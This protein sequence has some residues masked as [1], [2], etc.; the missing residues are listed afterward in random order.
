MRTFTLIALL[1][2]AA[3]LTY[4]QNP[5]FVKFKPLQLGIVA[6][7]GSSGVYGLKYEHNVSLN[8]FSGHAYA[9]NILSIAGI[10][11]YQVQR[12]Q[13]IN[14]AG[15]SN[16][17]GAFPFGK[18]R[19]LRDS[20]AE[21]GA[22]QVSGLIN[23]VNGS[24]FGGQLSGGINMVTGTLDGIQ[25][26]TLHNDVNKALS[27]GQIALISNRIGDMA[28]GLQSAFV[29]N[30]AKMMSGAQLFAL[31]NYVTHEL[32]GIQLGGFNSVSNRNSPTY[33]KNRF[34][35]MQLGLCNF[36]LENGDGYQ[37][38]LLNYGKNIGFAQLGLI[39]ISERIPQYP[40]GLLNLAGDIEGFLRAYT[41]RLF[42]Y[43][44]EMSTGSKKLLSALTYSWDGQRN[45]KGYSY[46]LGNQ[47]KKGPAGMPQNQYF[48]EAFIQVTNLVENGQSFLDPN[49]IYTIKTQ[50]GYNPFRRTK[51][52][53]LYFFVGLTGNA[54]WMD[55]TD[56]SL[57]E[58]PLINQTNDRSFWADVNF[59]IQL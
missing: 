45:R 15:I 28:L 46:A 14:I 39:N 55:T 57:I 42:R 24:G 33:R 20:L 6:G 19:M 41:S 40:V 9:N 13:G 58:G 23:G 4:A 2:V 53:D 54:T 50:V 35:W 21:F 1:L 8:V 52:M 17:L 16:I 51:M 48:Y 36:A 10:S 49:M 47:K 18:E 59:G 38:G 29:V 30:R 32:D 3:R 43:N 5:D 26:T 7:F 22:I 44:I 56:Q 11:H 27:G 34:Y 12:S 31:F 25:I 37:I